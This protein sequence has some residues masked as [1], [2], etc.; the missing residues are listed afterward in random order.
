MTSLPST[1]IPEL[2]VVAPMFNEAGGARALVAEIAA[3][4]TGLDHEIIV[5]D[6]CSTDAT[7]EELSAAQQD[8][9]QLRIL[10]HGANAGQSRAIHT[11]V[12]AARAPLVAM[13]DGDGQNDP[14]DIPALLAALEN[15]PDAVRM[16]AG[17]RRE[18][19]DPASKQW[20]SRMANGVRRRILRDGAADT[21]CGLKVFDRETFLALPYFDHMHRYLPALMARAGASV[22]FCPVGHRARRHGVSKY[23]NIGRFAVAIRDILGVS[24]L[25]ARARPPGVITEKTPTKEVRVAQDCDRIE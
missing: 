1:S 25:L 23:N 24:W 17:E 18:R 22:V 3:A 12:V 8:A 2:S 10:A 4:L 11:G 6:D 7:F 13:I 16:A 20:A 19:N 15:A 9:P 5:V 14:A 21:G